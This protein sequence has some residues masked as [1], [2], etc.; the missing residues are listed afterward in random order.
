VAAVTITSTNNGPVNRLEFIDEAMLYREYI[1][2]GVTPCFGSIY[3]LKE[4]PMLVF[5][6]S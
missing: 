6:D 1:F 2:P 5:A 3:Q 4:A